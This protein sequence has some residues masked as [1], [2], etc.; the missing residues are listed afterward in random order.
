[1]RRIHTKTLL[2]FLVLSAVT[3]FALFTLGEQRQN[4][5]QSRA[6]TGRLDARTLDFDSPL[7]SGDPDYEAFYR[8][9]PRGEFKASRSEFFMRKRAE[10]F[11]FPELSYPM[12]DD[13]P[14][15]YRFDMGP[16]GAPVKAGYIPIARGDLFSWEKGYGWSGAPTADFAYEGQQSLSFLKWLD[17]ATVQLRAISRAFEGKG[18]DYPRFTRMMVQPETLQF[19]DEFLDEVS[20][21]AVL[22]PDVLSFKV[23]LPN[24]RYQ[25]SMVVGD[26]QIPRYGIEVYA[27]GSRVAADLFTAKAPWRAAVVPGEPWPV[28]ISFPVRVVRNNLR[29]TLRANDNLFYER[30]EVAA[31]TPDYNYSQL[32]YVMGLSRAPKAT[33]FFGKRMNYHGPATQMALAGITIAPYE[34]PPLEL[35][36]QRLMVSRSVTDSHA[37]QGVERFNGGDLRGAEAHFD[38][39]PDSEARLKALAFLSLAGLLET[40]FAQEQRWADAAS[41][42]LAKAVEK[43]PENILLEDL[44]RV[45][46]FFKEAEYKLE[47]GVETG[48]SQGRSEAACLLN[49]IGPQDLLYTKKLMRYG[50]VF[51]NI[52]AH[53]WSQTWHV[54]E[55]TFAELEARVPG[56]RFSQYF[57]DWDPT[58]WDVKDYS[59]GTEDAPR[60]AVMMREAFNRLIDQADWWHRHRQ[61]P[62]GRLGGGWGDDVEINIVW[63]QLMLMNPDASPD[64]MEAVRALT[65]GV[66]WS[67][68]VDRDAGFFDGQA[69]VE[70]TAE[71]TG[72]SQALIQGID[73]GNPIYYERSLK[74]AKLMRDLWTGI[75]DKGH[76]HFKS[77]VLGNR[78]IGKSYGGVLDAEIDHPLNGRA[79]LPAFWAWWYSPTDELDRLF[80]EWAEAWWE[81]SSR[82]EN[83][84]PPWVIPGPIGF[85]TD[86]LG[87][88]HA[89]V[90][91][92]GAPK[93]NAYENPTYVEFILDLFS[94]MYGITGDEKWLLPVAADVGN[95][96]VNTDTTIAVRDPRGV[97]RVEDKYKLLDQIDLEYLLQVIRT[98]WPSV[99]SE[100]VSTDRIAMPGLNPIVELL[101][102]GKAL[103]GLDFVPMTFRETSRDIAFMNL[104]SS[105]THSKLI[106]Y[107]FESQSETVHLNLW[108]L[109]LGA[110]HSVVVGVD[111]QD[112]DEIDEVIQKFSYRHLHR[113]D[114]IRFDV[115]SKKPV[116]VEI[117]QVAPGARRPDRIV[118]LAMAAEDIEYRNGKIQVTI[119]N[120]GNKDCG[121][122][123]VEV[124]NGARGE[125]TRVERFE[126]DGL[127]APNDLEPR[128][129]RREL[130]WTSP[131]DAGENDPVRI[132]VVLDPENVYQ[133]ITERNNVVSRTIPYW[134]PEYRVPRVWDSLA[135]SLNLPR[136]QPYPDDFPH[137]KRR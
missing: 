95:Q 128:R 88:N 39:I 41:Q 8:T 108:N 23:A 133:E 15:H 71:W 56:N 78:T 69:D 52:D 36:R 38:R 127:G 34:P 91:R 104:V 6:L 45:T 57:L 25:V 94:R 68:E 132:T 1:M 126:V 100:I 79:L 119:H 17:Y 123:S 3:V 80:T 81:D 112:D 93:T 30:A 33:S 67:G 55:E 97:R 85:H 75:N 60:W 50:R 96:D 120:I 14:T 48:V 107:N 28:R 64:A 83:G 16:A 63:Q 101:T 37:L 117:R 43:D 24:G 31:E 105:P 10:A 129:I 98:T 137:E 40:D 110:E 106:L 29:L 49:W 90:W 18:R 19:Y 103:N 115:P 134:E 5:R 74:I 121:P 116:V 32:P 12:G 113:G 21:D 111:N 9:V 26:L 84:K 89:R 72:D 125:G 47:H 27:N 4:Q 62:D 51:A 2:T 73:Y 135:E 130:P 109:E 58:G 136:R 7:P 66:W 92:Q 44:L 118:D 22:N 86:T 102:G 13:N 76:R 131:G 46:R 82:A 42:V 122:F 59:K 11:E 61:L 53:R 20:R 70:H 54:A 114:A 77:M 124:W 99:T 65:E 87:G 35:V